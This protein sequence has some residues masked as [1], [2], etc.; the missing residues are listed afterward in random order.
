MIY[1]TD[2]D[3]DEILHFLDDNKWQLRGKW[4]DTIVD[5]LKNASENEPTQISKCAASRETFIVE[6]LAD[7]GQSSWA[8]IVEGLASVCPA[9][10][11][12]YYE[13]F[14][15]LHDLVSEGKVKEWGGMFDHTYE[16]A[17]EN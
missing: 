8:N 17:K 11:N 2:D 4:Y 9:G 13:W 6:Y 14:G 7:N 10:N 5:I 12:G 16:L 3:R 15:S 1:L